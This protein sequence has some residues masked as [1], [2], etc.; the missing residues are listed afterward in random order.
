MQHKGLTAQ[1]VI[2]SRNDFGSNALPERKKKSFFSTLIKNFKDPIIKILCIALAINIVLVIFGESEWYEVIGIACAVLVATLLASFSEYKNEDAF[3][4]LQKE[5]AKIYCKTYRDGNISEV[6]IDELVVGDC[7]V[8][9]AGDKIP[10]DGY[11]LSGQ[12]KVD[13]STLNGESEEVEK[14]AAPKDYQITSSINFFSEYDIFRG[15]IV[16]NGNGVFC[17]ASVGIKTV[18]GSIANELQ[19]NTKPDSPLKV[20]LSALAKK[21]ARF[22]YIGAVVI[23]IAFF[24]SNV[25]V[26]NNFD[27]VLISAMFTDVT[28]ILHVIVNALML[29]VVIIV[30][31]V[32]EGLPLM[33]ALV[34]S[35]NMRKMLKA[36]VLVRDIDGIETAGGLNILFT[37]KTGTI[38]KGK[39]EVVTFIDSEAN[40][41]ANIS[42]LSSYQKAEV[43][44]NACINTNAYFINDENGFNAI[45]GNATERALLNYVSEQ[46][47]TN[48]QKYAEIAFD[49]KNKYSACQ[50]KKDSVI[51]IKG[52]PEILLKRCSYGLNA[53]GQKV[54]IN[55]EKIEAEINKLTQKCIRVLALGICHGEI[56]DNAIDSDEWLLT[57]LVGIRDDIRKESFDAIKSTLA[58]GVQVV[59]ITGDK[60]ETATA[61]AKEIGLVNSESDVVLTSDELNNKSDEELA[62]ILPN[63]RV[64]SRALPS[65]KSR[66]VKVAQSLNLVCGM[67]GDGVNDSAAL[68]AADIG[69]AMGSGTEV[70]KEASEIV[71]LDDNFQSIENAILYGRTIYNNIRKFLI[72]QLTINFAAVFISIIMPLVANITPLTVIQILWIN[73]II[74]TFAAIALGGEPPRMSYMDER[75]RARDENIINKSMTASILLGSIWCLLL[76]LV[77]LLSGFFSEI[78]TTTDNL[79]TAYFTFFVF[80]AIFNAFNCRTASIN[81]FDKM[82][83]NKIFLLVFALIAFSQIIM[84]YFGGVVF[85]CYGLEPTQW[86][87]IL[88]LAFTIIPLDLIRKVIFKKKK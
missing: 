79:Y 81:L 70:A 86:I 56:K 49:S 55:L 87:V 78:F 58:A 40:T 5:N 17:V 10:A 71:I 37:D 54:K 69:F 77:I 13:Q 72:Y 50:K 66:L 57:G 59:M 33:I 75:P 3:Q 82:S 8:I 1:E 14:N 80:S 28:S 52:A 34:S 43:T 12:I 11:M 35:L 46:A 30:M 18:F 26:A 44:N 85:R 45:G 25:F 62:K 2:K 22:G 84:T 20:K 38:T 31:A 21:I 67:T 32:P 16:T 73:L 63:V 6:P 9:Q 88:V 53:N 23:A 29:A 7:V 41:Y 47:Y 39:L 51:Y 27:P 4:Q 42:E 83:S 74:D 68:K 76:S 19:N 36:N 61:I 48:T 65:D 15:S 24:F 60:K 64:I